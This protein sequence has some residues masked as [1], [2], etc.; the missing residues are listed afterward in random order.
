MLIMEEGE[1]VSQYF[2]KLVNLV[3]LANQ[4]IWNDDAITG[5]MKIEKVLRTF[6]PRFDHIVVVLKESKDLDVM[7]NFEQAFKHMN[8]G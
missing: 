5:L 4:M 3:N 2:D 1:Y 7:K 8:W 6:T